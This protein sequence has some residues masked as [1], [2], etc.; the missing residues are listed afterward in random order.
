MRNWIAL[1]N[2]I[3]PYS[4]IKSYDWPKDIPSETISCLKQ[5]EEI[6]FFFLGELLDV[7]TE[8]TADWSHWDDEKNR[9]IRFILAI[10]GILIANSSLDYTLNPHSPVNQACLKIAEFIAHENEAVCSI[11]MPLIKR[12]IGSN[13]TPENLQSAATNV[14]ERFVLSEF[15]ISADGE[16]LISLEDMIEGAR[17]D[18]N[19]F[20][21]VDAKKNSTFDLTSTDRA[22]IRRLNP[23]YF[24]QLHEIH[25]TK[26]GQK[27]SIGWALQ[28]LISGLLRSSVV[29]T[30]SETV[31]NLLEC[32]E[33][34]IAFYRHWKTISDPIK[35]KI[36]NYKYGTFTL[37][38]YLLCLFVSAKE[39]SSDIDINKELYLRIVRE[40]IF[41][42]AHQIAKSLESLLNLNPDLLAMPLPGRKAD[43]EQMRLPDAKTLDQLQKQAIAELGKRPSIMGINDQQVIARAQ[44][45]YKLMLNCD[46]DDFVLQKN[47]VNLYSCINS[48][49]DLT[50]AIV[51]IP[52]C[53]WTFFLGSLKNKWGKIF[54]H[55]LGQQHKTYLF[56]LNA[57][58]KSDWSE[59]FDALRQVKLEISLTGSDL[60][61]VL[62]GLPQNL[63]DVFKKSVAHLISKMLENIYHIANLFKQVPTEK[64]N[65]IYK[66]F[67]EPI[68]TIVT[69]PR[70]LGK[71]FYPFYASYWGDLRDIFQPLFQAV[72]QNPASLREFLLEL[73]PEQQYN[74]IKNIF[75]LNKELVLTT[76]LFVTLFM[77]VRKDQW[78][79][80]IRQLN[81][82][83]V[84]VF[85]SDGKNLERLF[86][87]LNTTLWSADD[88]REITRIIISIIVDTNDFNPMLLLSWRRLRNRFPERMVKFLESPICVAL[89]F[90]SVP[91]EHWFNLAFLIRTQ[92][93]RTLFKNDFLK[94]MI[95]LFPLHE[96]IT[97]CGVLISLLIDITADNMV[98]I[99]KT[100]PVNDWV[101]IVTRLCHKKIS[102]P[103]FNNARLLVNF[104]NQFE[105]D[106]LSVIYTLFQKY[107]SV[108]LDD[109]QTKTVLSDY[110]PNN[111]WQVLV[112]LL[113][114]QIT[115][116]K[117]T[118]QNTQNKRSVTTRGLFPWVPQPVLRPQTPRGTSLRR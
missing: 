30:G 39:F 93:Q 67:Q 61:I 2:E 64:W 35:N 21:A 48:L 109:P 69:N 76:E 86:I 20:F 106:Q 49:C 40:S 99:L 110:L 46:Q 41:P 28:E 51:L 3:E 116:T 103:L 54:F 108:I 44:V 73:E 29:D 114:A 13:P 1:L 11:L 77:A 95:F 15:L 104:F 115:R 75:G 19:S 31:A 88:W 57:I 70:M 65:L 52:K 27:P 66:T 9:R 81:S 113:P 92:L 107:M 71:L 8:E 55:N 94:N 7:V 117:L 56:I 34:I 12:V 17:N 84:K 91:S 87:Q 78:G 111:K 98:V 47:I 105:A 18:T 32:S 60:A 14:N 62:N 26:Q 33:P 6:D 43:F 63:W 97:V 24:N 59:F 23:T 37:E 36:K 96:R 45:C 42:C 90:H 112:P 5:L 101:E 80:C 10:R 82:A 72:I 118:H 16:S 38:S 79:S 58:P 89:M 68:D 74:F 102:T 83:R 53:E 25:R 85:F 4:L 100:F 22:H 50:G